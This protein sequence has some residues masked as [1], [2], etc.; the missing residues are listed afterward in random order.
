MRKDESLLPKTISL[1]SGA[2]GLDLGLEEAGIGVAACVE[3]DGPSC[4]TIRAN[5]SD[6]PVVEGDIRRVEPQRILDLAGLERGEAFL[7]SGGP[8]CQAFST[9]GRRG[10]FGDPRGSLFADFVRFVGYMRPEYFL[11]ENVRGLLSAAIEHR[12]LAER[13]DGHAPLK[14][15]ERLGSALEVILGEFDKLGYTVGYRL[16]NAVDYGVPQ[17]RQRIIFIGSREGREVAFPKPTHSRGGIG[18]LPPW[19]T[20]GDALS[21]LADESPEYP[22]YSEERAGIFEMVPAGGN[23]RSLPEPL[24]KE[25]LGGAYTS[26]GG[27]V[28]FYRRLSFDKA[29]P[30]IITSVSQKASG[31]CHP[32]ET[33]PL[34][35]EECRRIQEFPDGYEVCGSMAQKYTQIG[36]A[37]PVGLARAVGEAIL[38]DA[39]GESR[40]GDIRGEVAGRPRQL[41]LDFFGAS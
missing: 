16:L 31:M 10:S 35:V 24:Q 20:L 5:R 23:W 36:N 22:K 41:E 34:S 8:P 28:G 30:T 38:R 37:V 1:F 33:R 21:G 18:G 11:M 13:G 29:S 6:V 4:R 15:E 17:N 14:P 7:V 3:M 26:S 9:A 19:R 25:A 32:E 40:K 12:P 2:M 39:R 27:R